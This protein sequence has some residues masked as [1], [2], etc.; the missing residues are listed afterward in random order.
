MKII[1]FAGFS[2]SL[3]HFR[4]ELLIRMVEK[5]NFVIAVGPEAGYESQ[6]KEIGVAFKQI[7]FNRLSLNPLSDIK[8]IINLVKLMAIEKPDLYF[9]YTIKPV[10]YGAIAAY[11][12]GTKKRYSMVT[13]LG[14]VFIEGDEKK[15][16]VKSIVKILYKIGFIFSNKVFFQN[17]DDIKDMI[18]MRL[19]KREK[20]IQVNGSGVNLEY[21]VQS[22]IPKNDVF[23]FIGSLMRDKGIIEYLRASEMV[24]KRYPQ[25]EFW[26]V[27]PKD[28]R[29]SGITG[30]ELD[31]YITN[32]YIHYFG[33]TDDVRP[34]LDKCRY[35][36][37]PSYREGT[38]RSVLEAM[39]T[40]RP[41]IT[42]DVPGCRETVVDGLNG[43]L[44]PVKNFKLL[45]DKML[46][47]IE[48]T[49]KVKTMGEES[50]K[51]V[52]NKYDVLKINDIMM[53]YMNLK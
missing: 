45:A 37:L 25:A 28:S 14:S 42:T 8:L 35:Y 33:E 3:I 43:F 32:G 50:L 27:G 2:K 17:K 9:G 31:Y 7:E 29:L 1:V 49:S 23:L 16:Y 21:Y 53:H 15:K 18:R 51:I 30:A 26:V 52:Q 36:V 12:S 5:G 41:I 10:V 13:G 19:I 38:P 48:H 4:K 34:Y 24:K 11:L 47:M 6:L 22:A 39:A 40:G 46:W 20:C 44:V